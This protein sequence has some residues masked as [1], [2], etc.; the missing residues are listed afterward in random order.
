[1]RFVASLNSVTSAWCPSCAASVGGTLSIRS[2]CPDSSAATRPASF[3]RKRSVMRCQSGLPPHQSGF[4]CITTRSFGVQDTKRY[5]PV[6]I[7]ALPLL[8]SS[9]P[10]SGPSLA[11]SMKIRPICCIS[12]GVGTGVRMCRV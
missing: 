8:K 11:G 5:G 3:G 12:N 2:T 10:R 7:A 1:M 4:A 6:P 9:L